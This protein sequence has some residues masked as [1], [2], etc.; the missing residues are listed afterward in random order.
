M[1]AELASVSVIIPAYNAAI[2]IERALASALT[3]EGVDLEVIVVDDGSTDGTSE[4]VAGLARAEPRIRLIRLDENS[5]PGAA[6]NAALE[7]ASGDWVA[8]LDADDAYAAGRLRRLIALATERKADIVVD[9][10]FNYDAR[11]GTC[12]PPVLPPQPHLEMLT[13]YDFV[14]RSQ[15]FRAEVDYGLLKPI[16]RRSFLEAHRLRYPAASRHG[17]D[18]LFIFSALLEGAVYLLSREP[19]YLY[20]TRSSAMS[21]TRI[22]Y[23]T[24]A[25]EVRALLD[26]PAVRDDPLLRDRVLDRIAAIRRVNARHVV[27]DRWAAGDAA[28]LIRAI[29]RDRS[30][31]AEVWRRVRKMLGSPHRLQLR[32]EPNA[33]DRSVG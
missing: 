22:D 10:F 27:S 30:V 17:E 21:R 6:R 2:F 31:A 13:K 23:L 3:Q 15:G 5:G 24:M 8:I 26:W 28:G 14:E 33:R 4:L 12:G 29:L 18:F 20:T 7:A 16:L 32:G 11:S 9:N 25:E 1:P 19:S